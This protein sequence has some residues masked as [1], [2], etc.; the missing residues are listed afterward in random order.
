MESV[1]VTP[2][3][4]NTMAYVLIH[5]QKDL[6][7]TLKINLV[8]VLMD[9]RSTANAKAQPTQDLIVLKKMELLDLFNHSLFFL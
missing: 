3:I 9:K 8:I 1:T 6:P 5:A 2:L 7:Q 4:G